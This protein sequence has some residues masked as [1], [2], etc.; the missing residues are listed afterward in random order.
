MPQQIDLNEIRRK[1]PDLD[2]KSL[3][4]W[5]RLRR[6][7]VE[8]GVRGRQSSYPEMGKRAQVV[9]DADNDPRLVKVLHRN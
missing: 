7:L 5:K 9:D 2:W 8:R 1:N 6:V 4:E 3:A